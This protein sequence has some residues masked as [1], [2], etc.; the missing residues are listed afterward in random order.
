[1]RLVLNEKE[2]RD[3]DGNE[4]DFANYGDMCICCQF[5]ADIACRSDTERAPTSV[6]L[7][8]NCHAAKEE[9]VEGAAAAADAAAAPPSSRTLGL[10]G[11]PPPW[12][13]VFLLQ[14]TRRNGVGMG[15]GSGFPG[16]ITLFPRYIKVSNT[17][18]QHSY[19]I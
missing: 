17:C 1:M 2:A 9:E 3:S 10:M 19:M 14:E 16:C 6:F 12:Q 11:R 8:K 5:L 13:Q 4:S 18:F 15:R 7:V